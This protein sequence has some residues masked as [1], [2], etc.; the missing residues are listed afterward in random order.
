[1]LY[2]NTN[3]NATAFGS[4]I[5]ERLERIFPRLKILTKRPTLLRISLVIFCFWL[6][7]GGGL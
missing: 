4:A 7:L 6:E 5:L 3:E 1:M 2:H